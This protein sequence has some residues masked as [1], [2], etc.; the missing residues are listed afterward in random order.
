MRI[1]P[2][3]SEGRSSSDS[4]L[5]QDLTGLWRGPITSS[6]DSF[7]RT[8]LAVI[9]VSFSVLFILLSVFGFHQ[10]SGTGLYSAP[11]EDTL[12]LLLLPDELCIT[13]ESRS[14]VE[15]IRELD[16]DD[17]EIEFATPNLANCSEL[18]AEV[19]VARS[20]LYYF[21]EGSDITLVTLHH[22]ED[23]DNERT[24]RWLSTADRY[25]AVLP[26]VVLTV[27][28][29]G[30]LAPSQRKYKF[31]GAPSGLTVTPQGGAMAYRG[32]AAALFILT[33]RRAL[34]TFASSYFDVFCGTE[35]RAPIRPVGQRVYS[36]QQ[37]NLLLSGIRARV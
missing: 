31:L 29:L 32:A 8:R 28:T 2:E 15:G 12:E 18:E 21:G 1:H 3:A 10:L 16:A 26:P 14:N 23:T 13:S 4:V 19:A 35:T 34:N 9:G 27:F 6:S 36:D 24:Q 5:D 37:R 25:M 22:N 17:S 11:P 7:E 33:L 20:L 30:L